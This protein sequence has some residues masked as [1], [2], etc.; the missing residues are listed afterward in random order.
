MGKKVKDRSKQT[1]L[2]FGAHTFASDPA[3]A[4][5][6]AT[7][8]GSSS[9]SSPT[10][11]TLK[12]SQDGASGS[13]EAPPKQKT[14]GR[15]LG[16]VIPPSPKKHPTPSSS[17]SKP[18]KTSG[19]SSATKQMTFDDFRAPAVAGPIASTSSNPTASDPPSP[20]RSSPHRVN[21]GSASI[22]LRFGAS[23][24]GKLQKPSKAMLLEDLKAAR[25][26]RQEEAAMDQKRSKTRRRY[27]RRG[28]EGLAEFELESEG[29]DELESGEDEPEDA[30]LEAPP[31][32]EDD[33]AMPSP[34]RSARK[35]DKGK[36]K[37]KAIVLDSS[38]S[39]SSSDSKSGSDSDESLPFRPAPTNTQKPST[40]TL[41]KRA[42]VTS[43][44][45]SSD[46]SDGDLNEAVINS[47]PKK[48]RTLTQSHPVS[49]P[50]RTKV[51]EP[52]GS[53]STA[54]STKLSPKRHRQVRQNVES[55]SSLP[56][57]ESESDDLEVSG[58]EEAKTRLREKKQ[59]PAQGKFASLRKARE[60][61]QKREDRAK[62]VRATGIIPDTESEEDGGGSEDEEDVEDED[63][64]EVEDGEDE[65]EEDITKYI[66]DDTEGEGGNA[67]RAEIEALMPQQFRNVSRQ[68]KIHHFRVRTILHSAGRSRVADDDR[69]LD[70]AGHMPTLHP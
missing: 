16:V 12:A 6:T 53:Q 56:S 61:R 58:F 36:G 13:Q 30:G 62:A 9:K 18:N 60:A 59:N 10:K 26:E 48:S 5:P 4:A 31:T 63:E 19:V 17:P 21:H 39:S 29:G 3:V 67:T 34:K 15:F 27:R 41:K 66:V 20:S 11:K 40:S 24:S 47:P 57:E 50:T 55:E 65:T 45:A 25:K 64:D 51:K 42:R 35:P 70:L 2:D 46:D 23:A 37:A 54:K 44:S 22:Q 1:T 43:S 68:T 38:S 52:I 33:D 69:T 49:S 8:S 28:Y 7:A 14:V 32:E